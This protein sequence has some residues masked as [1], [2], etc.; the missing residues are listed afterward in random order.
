M[1]I[2]SLSS[3]KIPTCHSSQDYSKKF[4]AGHTISC[5]Y[6][7][8]NRDFRNDFGLVRTTIALC[9]RVDS[10]AAYSSEEDVLTVI[11]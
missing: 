9:A 10:A 7:S 4:V 11:R 5:S 3:K 2:L 1:T 6:N 8:F